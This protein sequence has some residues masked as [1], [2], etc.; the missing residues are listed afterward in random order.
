[1]PSAKGT[2]ICASAA[3]PFSVLLANKRVLARK[4]GGTDVLPLLYLTVFI[5]A[6]KKENVKGN[7]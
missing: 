6:H 2:R 1:M 7:D 4:A 3:I 5:L